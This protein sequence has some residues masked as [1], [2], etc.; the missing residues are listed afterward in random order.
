MAATTRPRTHPRIVVLMT[1]SYIQVV[2]AVVAVCA[3]ALFG[4]SMLAFRPYDGI[5]FGV[6]GEPYEAYVAS[7][8]ENGPAERAGIRAGDWIQTIDGQ[9]VD[10]WGNTPLYRPYIRAGDSIVYELDRD[11]RRLTTSATMG[12]YRENPTL[13]LTFVG[14][15][16]LSLFFW[17]IGLA[18]CLFAATDDIRA[19]LVGLAWLLGAVAMAAGGPGT[20]SKFW[21]AYTTLEVSWCVLGMVF[22][23]MHMYFP[24]PTFVGQRKLIVGILMVM[25]LV[26]SVLV[27]L[28]EWL[29][30]PQGL[31]LPYLLGFRIYEFVYTFFL[32]SVLASI[33][34][35]LRNRLVTKDAAIKQ[36][37]SIVFWG[38]AAGFIPFLT[39]GVMPQILFASPSAGYVTV[40][41][42][43]FM[44]LAYAYA[45]HQR[46]LIHIDFFINR[47]VVFFV[48][49]V[50]VLIVSTLTLGAIA[51]ILELSP[52]FV[53]L[54]GVVT[55]M[56]AIPS[57][58]LRQPVQ[59]QVNRVL[60]GY[61]YD[62]QMITSDFSSQLARTLG[63]AKLIELL[64][65][66]LPQRM[67]IKQAALFLAE[68]ESL[69]QGF[70]ESENIVP[71][72]ISMDD[73]LCQSLSEHQT[74]MQATGVQQSLSDDALSSWRGY[75]W[76]RLFVPLIFESQLVG[77]LALGNRTTGDLYSNDDIHLV[78]TIAQQ[79]ALA[80]TSVRM[81]E[82]LR[83]LNRRLV[84]K[85]EAH[86]K[87]VA[88][89]LHDTAL[90]KLFFVKE[91]L[92][93]V[94]EKDNRVVDLVDETIGTLRG[95]IRDQRP[96]AIEQG[97]VFAMGGMVEEMQ[98]LAD[99]RPTVTLSTDLSETSKTGLSDEKATALYRIAQEA[100]VNALKHADAQ[101]IDVSITL[102]DNSILML[103]I[104]DDGV[105]MR[106]SVVGG[107]GEHH[108][109]LVG[110]QERA[111]MIGAEL[112]IISS[113]GEGTSI[114]VVIC[115]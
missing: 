30:N 90:Q 76:V 94:A 85:D 67:G 38:T 69:I 111:A 23:T 45:I 35:L 17:G 18:I 14:Q 60:Y 86:R 11:G 48:L 87:H 56:I 5:R 32:L 46:K 58:S 2:F 72:S 33:G 83:G 109:G 51:L 84:R 73:K 41:F 80:Y 1:N 92:L 104:E 15:L 50:L 34:L 68:G 75:D 97:L 96:P 31:E 57:T 8:H 16:L 24:A 42:L 49:I 114:E 100:I 40:L 98:R 99:D 74:P 63:R 9:V 107:I 28:N 89:E 102:E 108:Y 115:L 105:G 59:R 70:P 77:L 82:T 13:L 19:R 12:S 66:S 65:Q 101:H 43:V 44:P 78:A 10:G 95:M 25:A 55:S 27:V 37:V 113:P 26:L 7:V 47:A 71:K 112:D 110:M 52:E 106:P 21:G 20:F 4:Y 93:K 61:H 54:G 36:Q 81:V 91:S 103:T 22:L 79:G 53:L 6:G 62:F 3:I 39:L 88:R 64:A 29:L